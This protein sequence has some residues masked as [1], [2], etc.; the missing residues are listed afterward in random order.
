VISRVL[1]HPWNDAHIALQ[2]VPRWALKRQSRFE[3]TL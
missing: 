1:E 2:G 3:R